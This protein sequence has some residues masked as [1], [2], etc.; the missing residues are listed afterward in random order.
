MLGFF[1]RRVGPTSASTLLIVCL[2]VGHARAQQTYPLPAPVYLTGTANASITVAFATS[3]PANSTVSCSL[4]L[5]G[6]DP[7]APRDTITVTAPVN[8]ATALCPISLN[9][10][11]RLTDPSQDTMAI[12][13]GVQ[14]PSQSSIGIVNIIPMPSDGYIA[15]MAFTVNQ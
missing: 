8:G 1:Q 2:F 11:W 14:G 12:A 7:R 9:Y 15:N 4:A 5:I 13:Y 10:R 6:S 3:P